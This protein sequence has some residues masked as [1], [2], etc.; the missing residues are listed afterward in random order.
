MLP[1]VL[2]PSVP[3]DF[4]R[5]LKDVDENLTIVFNCIT[6][7]WEVHRFSKGRW[8][9]ILAVE[10]EDGS[11]R[12]LDNRIFKKLTEMDIIA[13]WGSVANYERHL[14]E[15]QKK[16][17]DNYQKDVDHELKYD[18]KD[19]NIQWQEA[20]DNFRSGKVNPAPMH[21]DKKITSYPKNGGV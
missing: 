9:W 19:N 18:I 15:K 8:Q 5:K 6:E 3:K 21:S 13:K 10:E 17:Q 1:T 4:I 11:Y 7:R 12:K 2:A 20:I 14:D 16:W